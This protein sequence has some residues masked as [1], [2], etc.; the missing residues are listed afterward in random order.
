[1]WGWG[2]WG[3]GMGIMMLIFWAAIIVGIV[4]LVRWLRLQGHGASSSGAGGES[5]LDIA[6][7]RY[8]A[9][10]ITQEEFETL[11]RSLS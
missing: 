6:K 11:K 7:R 10:E 8:A 5:P 9:G 3:L 2:V 1:M 4:A